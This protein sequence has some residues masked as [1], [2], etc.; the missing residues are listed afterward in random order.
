MLG[1]RVVLDRKARIG[2]EDIGDERGAPR[3]LLGLV[4]RPQPPV[5]RKARELK[6]AVAMRQPKHHGEKRLWRRGRTFRNPR[7]RPASLLHTFNSRVGADK[8]LDAPLRGKG[9]ALPKLAALPGVEVETPTKHIARPNELVK[10]KRLRKL[11]EAELGTGD[12]HAAFHAAEILSLR[13]AN[14]KMAD[15]F[16]QRPFGMRRR[17]DMMRPGQER[18][19]SFQ[20]A[21]CFKDGLAILQNFRRHPA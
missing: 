19:D 17:R 16:R 2:K 12:E 20:M 18:E 3:Y 7:E 1:R 21:Q 5:Y 15:R 4:A 11:H 9:L 14:H 8:G 10:R 13:H 6:A